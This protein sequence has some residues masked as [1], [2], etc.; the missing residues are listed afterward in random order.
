M[1][2]PTPAISSGSLGLSMLVL[3]FSEGVTQVVLLREVITF[4]GGNELS[5]GTALAAW[6]LWTAAGS[7]MAAWLSGKKA[8]SSPAPVLLLSGLAG[9]GS[10]VCAFLLPPWLGFSKGITPG[11]AGALLY[12]LIC[13]APAGFM[14]GAHYPLLLSVQT[15]KKPDQSGLARLYGLESLGGALAGLAFGL[16]LVWILEPWGIMLAVSSLCGCA[17]LLS[18]RPWRFAAALWICAMCPLLFWAGQ[19]GAWLEHRQWKGRGLLAISESPY[20]QL[21]VTG[22]SR[23]KNFFASGSWLF[24]QPDRLN[25]ER[26]AMVPLLAAPRAETA[27]LIGGG[28]SGEAGAM[29]KHGKLSRAAAVEL[30]PWLVELAGRGRNKTPGLEM[31]YGDG[32]VYMARTGRRFDLAVVSLPPPS[33]LQLNRYYSREGLA[34]LRRVLTPQGVAVL[35]L[36][37]VPHLMGPLEASRLKCVL[38]AAR[39]SFKGQVLYSDEEL[40]ICLYQKPVDPKGLDEIWLERLARKGWQDAVGVRPDTI[41]SALDPRRAAFLQEQIRQAPPGP[42]N[43]DYLPRVLLYDPDLWGVNLGGLSWLARWLAGLDPTALLWKLTQGLLLILLAGLIYHRASRNPGPALRSGVAVSGFSGMAGSLILLVIFQVVSGAVYLGLA[44]LIAAFMGGMGIAALLSRHGK[45]RLAWLAALHLGL[46]VC[47]FAMGLA[48]RLMP[49]GFA[50]WPLYVLGT[51]LGVL[52]GL[53]FAWA[54]ALLA[55]PPNK[56]QPSGLARLGGGLYGLDLL[57]GMLGAL[58]PAVLLPTVGLDGALGAALL[59]NL[60]L[61]LWQGVVARG[62]G[63]K[64]MC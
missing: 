44:L 3:G 27:L 63:A 36:P 24:S 51:G 56:R 64:E 19:T 38:A 50:A 61:A 6:L 57:G 12:A 43:A 46:A 28:A 20:A 21:S 16:I 10:L 34:A 31:V 59:F 15:P 32:R 55:S 54:G 22:D 1:S 41:M 29:L 17:A 30:D 13:L 58:A 33:T 40:F 42:A 60:T 53:Y 11:L 39:S 45:P 47:F 9:L 14:G 25:L 49:S 7:F 18:P 2:R 26:R 8:F 4:A 37:G 48:A 23:Q 35:R 52:S 62:L 5:L